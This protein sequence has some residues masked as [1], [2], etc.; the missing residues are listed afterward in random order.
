MTMNAARHTLI[1]AAL[2]LSFAPRGARAQNTDPV[3][4]EAL[5]QEGSRLLDAA[6]YARACPKL[7]ESYRLDPGTG[8]LLKIALCHERDRKLASAWTE[9]T[10]ALGRAQRE[11]DSEREQYAREQLKRLEP[12]LSS[13][14]IE[15]P[16]DAARIPGLEI[17]RDAVVLGNST[18]NTRIPIDGG[19]HRIEVSAPGKEPFAQTLAIADEGQAAHVIVPALRDASLESARPLAA[20]PMPV[21]PV[22]PSEPSQTA[23]RGARPWGT[24]EW[25]GIAS[26]GAGVVALGVGGY[27]LADALHK[28]GSEPGAEAQGNRATVCTVIGGLLLAGGATSFIVGRF[29]RKQASSVPVSVAI[30]AGPGGFDAALYGRF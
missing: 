11:A 6:D 13:L 25:A 4:S 16:P 23:E 3:A 22:L 21:A 7:A 30:A 24:L 26:A 27:F 14:V 5:F 10:E 18:W 20:E 28:N 15:V 17:R 9:L 12:R 8:T 2:A 1:L 29:A 19:E